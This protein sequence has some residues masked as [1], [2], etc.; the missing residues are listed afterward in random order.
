MSKNSAQGT[1]FLSA[2]LFLCAVSITSPAYAGTFRSDNPGVEFQSPVGWEIS[3]SGG[4]GYAI[5][6]LPGAKEARSTQGVGFQIY[7]RKSWFGP[8]LPSGPSGAGDFFRAMMAEYKA[9]YTP[10]SEQETTLGGFPAKEIIYTNTLTSVSG[11][12]R[13]KQIYVFVNGSMFDIRFSALE[14]VFERYWD[15]F[16]IVFDTLKFL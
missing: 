4:P 10:I 1:L 12:V 11:I 7:K 2:A 16:K 9:V 14:T 5:F 8:E 13:H 15:E 3:E 6:I